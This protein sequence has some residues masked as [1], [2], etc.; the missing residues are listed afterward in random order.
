M[1]KF[2]LLCLLAL[3]AACSLT[4]DRVEPAPPDHNAAVVFDIDG[5]LT[6]RVHAVRSVRSGAVAAVQTYAAAGFRI[7]YLSARHPLFQWYIP[8]W[9]E[10]H[11]FPVGAIQ[12]TASAEQ[13]RDHASF[14]AAVLEEYRA[15]GWDLIA[16]YGD[17]S[18]DFAAYA[19]AGIDRER[20]F[21]LQRE[22]A[23]AC[24]PGIWAECFAGWPEQMEIIEELAAQHP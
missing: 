23:D 10:H 8:V 22:D 9:L 5:T 14:K 19:E 6:T 7:V 16:A 17:S 2:A 1:R 20:V 3:C 15:S 18:S 12:V 13:R 4:P 11:G 21:A 24:E